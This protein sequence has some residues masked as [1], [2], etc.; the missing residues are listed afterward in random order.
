MK[1]PYVEDATGDCTLDLTALVVAVPMPEILDELTDGLVLETDAVFWELTEDDTPDDTDDALEPDEPDL[2][3]DEPDLDDD[4]PE[5]RPPPPDF[6]PPPLDDEPDE[7]PVDLPDDLDLDLL[8]RDER[9]PPRP[10]FF[11][12]IMI[13]VYYTN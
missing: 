10:P 5:L 2:E 3:P 9:P 4:L 12:P 8:E 11:L 7:P 13:C 1:L 6:D